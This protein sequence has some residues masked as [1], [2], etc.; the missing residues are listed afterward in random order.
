MRFAL[1]DSMG[2][3]DSCSASFRCSLLKPL[4]KSIAM[5][6]SLSRFDVIKRLALPPV[7]LRISSTG[8]ARLTDGRKI[9]V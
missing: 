8:F 2:E 1:N 7:T 4:T 9:G 3:I 6:S 5:A